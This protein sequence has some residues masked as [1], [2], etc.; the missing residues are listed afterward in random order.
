M[1]V[2][3]G[4]VCTLQAGIIWWILAHTAQCSAFHERVAKLEERL[5]MRQ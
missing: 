3:L 1:E 5:G 2:A 4:I